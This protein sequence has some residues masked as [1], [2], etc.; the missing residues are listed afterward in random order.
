M[1]KYKLIALDMD[2]TL[3]MSDKRIHPDTIRDI[4]Y[5]VDKGVNIVYSTGRGPV[6][7]KPV[8]AELPM[9][10]WGICASGSQVYDFQEKKVVFRKE[11]PG[12]L[13][14]EVIRIVGEET[15]MVNFLTDSQSIARADQ[16]ARMEEFHMKA[17]QQV[18]EEVAT[19]VPSMMEEAK[20]HASVPK[21][22]IYFRSPADREKAFAD[23]RHLPLTYILTE[24]TSLE[25]TAEGVTKALGL[26]KLAGHLGIS[27][28][29][30]VGIGDG[31]NDRA[32]LELAGFAV[33][34]RNATP[35]IQRISDF[36]TDDNDHNGVGKAIRRLIG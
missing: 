17:Y 29:E 21:M 12:E 5:A 8:A 31:D 2:G 24:K 10:R 18:Y 6:E 15:G 14:R 30:T 19:I 35:G 11:I 20:R 9:I 4:A 3:L 23:L 26:E 33:A 32:L 34:M 1:E 28:E 7:L 13:V 36:V 16:I 27:L 25:I 22:N